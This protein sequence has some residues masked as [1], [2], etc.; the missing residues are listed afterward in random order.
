MKI[1]Y[2]LIEL[3]AGHFATFWAR[4]VAV[5][6]HDH[7]LVLHIVMSVL[8]AERCRNLSF[9]MLQLCPLL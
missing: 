2:G 4:H 5:N 1:F 7:T 9:V 3:E 6:D 8:S